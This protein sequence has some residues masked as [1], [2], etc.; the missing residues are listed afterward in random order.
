MFIQMKRNIVVC[1]ML[2]MHYVREQTRP[3]N[4]FHLCCQ[5]IAALVLGFWHWS[6]CHYY[7]CI[8]YCIRV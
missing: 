6:P 8:D 5:V 2:R 4:L 7:C 3:N 1:K